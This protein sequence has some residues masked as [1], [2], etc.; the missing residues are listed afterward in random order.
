MKKL[1]VYACAEL[2]NTKQMVK[3]ILISLKTLKQ[4]LARQV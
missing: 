1:L 2:D 3:I 4:Q